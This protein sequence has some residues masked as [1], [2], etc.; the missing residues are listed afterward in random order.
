MSKIIS[1][2]FATFISQMLFGQNLQLHYDFGK[3]RK[4]FTATIEM[5]KPDSMGSTFFFTD[6]D[7]NGGANNTMSLSYF[8][9]ARYITLPILDK[10]LDATIQFNDGHTYWD[11]VA[12]P[13]GQVW[14]AG[15]SYPLNLKV[16]E[17]KIDLLYRHADYSKSTDWQFTAAWFRPFLNEKL[18]FAGFVDVWSEKRESKKV[19]FLAEPQI[20]FN[21][22]QRLF[23]GGEL[24]L[25]H[26]FLPTDRVEAIPTLGL[27]WY[28]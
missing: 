25:S 3:D 11:N 19:V 20:W 1:I 8:E 16:I 4:F 18:V 7:F 27:Q 23:L 5:F 9:I 15:F 10:K 6:F 14:L 24:E 22:W 17:I 12:I 28:F 21:A 26:N 13:L 2:L